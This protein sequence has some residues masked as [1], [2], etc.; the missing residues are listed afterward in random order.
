MEKLTTKVVNAL[1]AEAIEKGK[2][3]PIKVPDSSMSYFR[4]LVSKYNKTSKIKISVRGVHG[5]YR[6]VCAPQRS[7]L[8]TGDHGQA[9]ALIGKVLA[10]D[11]FM[12]SREQLSMI[13]KKLHSII[14]KC[15]KQCIAKKAIPQLETNDL[16]N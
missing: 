1:I 5:V 8:D 13:E 16:L 11:N 10:D 15:Q 9:F 6:E 2:S 4:M 14:R 12:I 3:N 7:I